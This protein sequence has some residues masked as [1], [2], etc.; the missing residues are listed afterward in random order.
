[1][2]IC[3]V[4]PISGLH[5]LASLSPPPPS[6][7]HPPLS[8][9]FP[10]FAHVFMQILPTTSQCSV[11]I[12]ALRSLPLCLFL[13]HGTALSLSHSVSMHH[14]PPPPPLHPPPPPL[15]DLFFLLPLPSL[16]LSSSKCAW[17]ATLIAASLMFARMPPTLPL[18]PFLPDVAQKRGI[19]DLTVPSALF[20]AQ[21]FV[22]V[23]NLCSVYWTPQ[24]L[25][26]SPASLSF[27]HH[28]APASRSRITG[29]LQFCSVPP[30]IYVL[31]FSI[32]PSWGWQRT[33]FTH[34]QPSCPF[35]ISPP[36]LLFIFLSLP[37][38]PPLHYSPRALS[39][40]PLSREMSAVLYFTVTL[41]AAFIR[42]ILRWCGQG[43]V[44]IH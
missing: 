40:L 36:D 32:L 42:F 2:K 33:Y 14:P 13:V 3:P 35:C 43:M 29:E 6:S 20:S 24:M 34:T 9:C 11:P 5:H 28:P 44:S 25:S 4:K 37:T 15:I 22:L 27:T 8:S 41:K 19:R 12:S 38:N 10:S 7:L 30:L 18:C 16:P 26:S 1:M 31:P 39:S 23:W 17:I 21:S